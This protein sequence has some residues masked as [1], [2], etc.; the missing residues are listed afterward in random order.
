[1]VFLLADNLMI[2]DRLDRSV[3]VIFKPLGWLLVYFLWNLV[4]FWWFGEVAYP[5]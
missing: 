3:R 4:D 5:D 1:M 2:K